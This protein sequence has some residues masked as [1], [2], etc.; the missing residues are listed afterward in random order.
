MTA[1][2]FLKSLKKIPAQ[3][4]TVSVDKER[5]GPVTAHDL[6]VSAAKGWLKF[7]FEADGRH[8]LRGEI[9]PKGKETVKLDGEVQEGADIVFSTRIQGLKFKIVVEFKLASGRYRFDGTTN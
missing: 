5:K 6:G 1:F 4:W 8:E 7:V 3:R 9:T 2:E